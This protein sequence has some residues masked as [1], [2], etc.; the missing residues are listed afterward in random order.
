MQ[1]RPKQIE[2]V[3]R[4]RFKADSVIVHG[5]FALVFLVPPD[6]EHGA[7][8]T[9]TIIQQTLQIL[10]ERDP[11]FNIKKLWIQLDNPTSEN[12]KHTL[13]GYSATLV[14]QGVIE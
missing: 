7:N 8:M 3:I 6:Q 11:T 14:H 5:R 1:H 12:K 13:H 4:P 9:C 10:Q 2:T